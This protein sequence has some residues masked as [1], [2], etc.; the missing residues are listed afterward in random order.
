MQKVY[1]KSVIALD[2]VPLA[3]LNGTSGILYTR[4]D[5]CIAIEAAIQL[6]AIA[7]VEN[8]NGNCSTIDRILN[9]QLEGALGVILYDNTTTDVTRNKVKCLVDP[10]LDVILFFLL[11]L[12][13]KS[14][15]FASFAMFSDKS[16]KNER[17]DIIKIKY[18]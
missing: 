15:F 13:T 9:A 3:F 6:P 17:R 16:I 7:L 5:P 10:Q 14:L 12:F 1:T 2:H 8:E 11:F 18:G 4:E